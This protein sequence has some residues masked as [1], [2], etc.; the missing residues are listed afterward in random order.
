MTVPNEKPSH[1][2]SKSVNSIRFQKWRRLKTNFQS[3][4]FICADC[5]PLKPETTQNYRFIQA[6]NYRFV[7][8][9]DVI[10]KSSNKYLLKTDSE[11][12]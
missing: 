6:Q 3:V 11:C 10:L 7:L 12:L 4:I 8:I 1:T 9:Y 5:T 2:F